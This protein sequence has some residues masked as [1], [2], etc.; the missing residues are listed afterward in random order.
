[1]TF[2]P[3]IIFL[4]YQNPA[5]RCSKSAHQIGREP[6]STH[7]RVH[8]V[9]Q[10]TDIHDF[11][12]TRKNALVKASGSATFFLMSPNTPVIDVGSAFTTRAVSN[13][14]NFETVFARILV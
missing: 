2:V 9:G 14:M 4:E 1:V 10:Y 8:P 6:A 7:F 11:L 5:P 3:V 12:A 13:T